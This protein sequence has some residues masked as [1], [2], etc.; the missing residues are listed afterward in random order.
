MKIINVYAK[1]FMLALITVIFSACGNSSPDQEVAH[2]LITELPNTGGAKIEIPT[3]QLSIPKGYTST[4]TGLNLSGGLSGIPI[5]LSSTITL[6]SDSSIQNVQSLPLAVKFTP[7]SLTT[8][9]A[10]SSSIFISVTGTISPGIYYINLYADYQL[11]EH[12]S[13]GT[14][15]L[16]VGNVVPPD[17]IESGNFAILPYGGLNLYGI[18]SSESLTIM[19]TGSNNISGIEVIINSKSGNFI[20]EPNSCNL[21][22]G[23]STCTITIKSVAIGGDS[24]EVTALGYNAVITPVNIIAVWTEVTGADIPNSY[25]VSSI[26]LESG[27]LYAG[28][29]S[30]SST[31]VVWTY[32]GSSWL[33]VSGADIPNGEYV[34]SIIF[35]SGNL[36]AGG[37]SKANLGA[38]WKYNGTN[39]VE[40]SGADISN[41]NYV[42][43]ITF[44]SGNLYAG[45]QSSSDTGVVWQYRGN[46]WMMVSSA[47]IPNSDRVN[48]ITF[49]S[50]NLYAGGVS[51]AN[52]GAV[53]KYN[54]NNW[55]LVDSNIVNSSYVNSI[56]FESGNLYASGRTNSD[57]GA[58]WRYNG[59]NWET[60]GGNIANSYYTSSIVFENGILYAGGATSN[61]NS[62]AVWMF[63][64]IIWVSVGSKLPHQGAV[65]LIIFNNGNLY[66]GGISDFLGAGVW[67]Y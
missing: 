7:E 4:S 2:S 60:V 57:V 3:N 30:N 51:N 11:K 34:N 43:S 59:I 45:G 50:S 65:N 36:Y 63:N 14:I 13:L 62:T 24:L 55:I 8:G 26:V 39:W 47:D 35:E 6:Q 41:S 38:V 20:I 61:I 10:S 12:V 64:G 31:G 56:I 25:S 32:N 16:K 67:I 5:N 23:N 22:T 21:S 52:L 66:A 54:G 42:N 29:Q 17:T 27:N 49:E 28:G 18:E 44:E 46:S 53:W 19:L 9:S 58:V 48:S 40:I 15:A 33:K 37:V 1:Y